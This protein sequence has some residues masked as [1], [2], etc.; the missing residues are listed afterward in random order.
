MSQKSSL[1]HGAQ[2]SVRIDP[3]VFS[4]YAKFCGKQL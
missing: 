4:S 1:V 2:H 3:L